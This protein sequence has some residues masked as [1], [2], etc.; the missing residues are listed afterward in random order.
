LQVLDV[1][2]AR[3][4]ASVI[5]R[6]EGLEL[7]QGLVAEIVAVDQEQDAASAGVLDQ[8]IAEVAGGE[9]LAA[10]GRHLDQGARVVRGERA[11]EVFDRLD[12][13]A[14]QAL[15]DEGRH[16]LQAA[17]PRGTL[18]EPLGERFGLVEGEYRP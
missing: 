5:G 13:A 8:P 10:A 17:T 15:R 2:E 16:L 4:V 9:G 12:L 1:V 14:P 18:C 3:E 11:L 7:A 6:R